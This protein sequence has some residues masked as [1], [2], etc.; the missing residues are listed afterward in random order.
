M[1]Q[2]EGI[3]GGFPHILYLTVTSRKFLYLSLQFFSTKKHS[4][5]YQ[6]H[7]SG[8]FFAVSFLGQMLTFEIT[9]LRWAQS[10]QLCQ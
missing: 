6:T 10:H 8:V 4:Q 2:H 5:L 3:L 1:G 9:P 7:L